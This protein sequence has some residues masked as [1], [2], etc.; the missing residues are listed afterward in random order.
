MSREIDA[1]VVSGWG[2]QN[3]YFRS[4]PNYEFSSAALLRRW[5][6]EA[7]TV[8]TLPNS[9]RFFC[10]FN[11]TET[12]CA[13]LEKREGGLHWDLEVVW[14]GATLN[15]TRHDCS[16]FRSSTSTHQQLFQDV[17]TRKINILMLLKNTGVPHRS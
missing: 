1:Q 2:E 8:P 10:K 14:G 9:Q 3:W 13:A 17:L 12:A 16:T 11:E 7:D 6:E 4:I 5:V 15:L